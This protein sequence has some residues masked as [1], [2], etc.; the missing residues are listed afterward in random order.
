VRVSIGF[1]LSLVSRSGIGP[2]A[3]DT[4][5][6]ASSNRSL[7]SRR[8]ELKGIT[9]GYPFQT[10][11]FGVAS[12]SSSVNNWITRP[13][14]E[15]SIVCGEANIPEGVTCERGWRSA[16]V[17]GPL[18]FG[19]TGVVA[20]LTTTLADAGVSVFVLSTYDTDYLLVKEDRLDKAIEAPKSLGHVIGS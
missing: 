9:A 10:A 4:S 18:D 19:L 14:D 6:G 13:D 2:R 17:Q 5:R 3:A 16:K 12:K 15:L 8:G 1:S 20:S 11:K 7:I